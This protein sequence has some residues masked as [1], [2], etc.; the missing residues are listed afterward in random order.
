MTEQE[1]FYK[2]MREL[3]EALFIGFGLG[4]LIIIGV[5]VWVVAT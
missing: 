4:V 5:F 2:A 3:I 1:K